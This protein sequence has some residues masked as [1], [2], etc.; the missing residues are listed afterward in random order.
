M[1]LT[2]PDNP[3][4]QFGEKT[5]NQELADAAKFFEAVDDSKAGL[6]AIEAMK[7]VLWARLHSDLGRYDNGT[8]QYA[9]LLDH[10]GG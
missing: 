7:C 3:W 8:K 2:I 10:E 1:P 6:I 4:L 9:E 5:T